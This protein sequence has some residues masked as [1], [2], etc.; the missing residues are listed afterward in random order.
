MNAIKWIHTHPSLMAAAGLLCAT[1]G[2]WLLQMDH[3][4]AGLALYSG[5]AALVVL[6]LRD[7]T[8]PA[9]ESQAGEGVRRVD[10]AQVAGMCVAGAAALL[11]AI[12]LVMQWQRSITPAAAWPWHFVAW[13]AF[14]LGWLI[15]LRRWTWLAL[16]GILSFALLTRTYQL[17]AVPVGLWGDEANDGLEA[18][19]ILRGEVETP[20]RNAWAGNPGLHQ[21]VNALFFQIMGANT[22]TLR[23]VAA[24][25]GL[26]TIGLTYV[27]GRQLWGAPVGLL[28]AFLLTISRWHIHRSRF[29]SVVVQGIPFQLLAYILLMRALKSRR[30]ADFAL[31]GLA[32]GLSLNFYFG[33]RV[34]PI[35]V[36]LVLLHAFASRPSEFI[37]LYWQ[38]CL[39]LIVGVMITFGPVG[40]YY[41]QEPQA[42]MGRT[43]NV[44][45]FAA[46][47]HFRSQYPDMDPTPFNILRT[48]AG[49][50]A[51]M[52]NYQ[53]GA[54]H[55]FNW[56]GQPLLDPL[57]G[58][59]FVLGFCCA[60]WR[61]RERRHA[62]LLAWLLPTLILGSVLTVGAPHSVRTAGA[63]PAVAL[64]AALASDMLWRAL[65]PARRRLRRWAL[66]PCAILWLGLAAYHN[67]DAYF[68]RYMPDPHTWYSRSSISTTLG[69][70]LR[71]HVESYRIA[72]L[73]DRQGSKHNPVL[74]FS[75]GGYEA[76]DFRSPAEMIPLDA[77]GMQGTIFVTFNG[78][79]VSYLDNRYPGGA[80][81]TFSDPW[82]KPVWWTYRVERDVIEDRRGLVGRYYDNL[83]GD[84]QPLFRRVDHE[85]DFQWPLDAPISRPFAVEWTG[86]IISDGEARTLA[87]ETDAPARVWIDGDL[88]IDAPT[89]S[90]GELRLARGH[91]EITI[92]AAFPDGGVPLQLIWAEAGGEF[93]ATP[94][95]V[96][97][98]WPDA[99][100]LLGAYYAN[101]DWAGEPAYYQVDPLMS[102]VW[103]HHDDPLP[104]PFSVE[105][106][107]WLRVEHAGDY[108]FSTRSYDASQIWIGDELVADKARGGAEQV[109]GD[110]IAL[111][112]GEHPIRIRYRGEAGAKAVRVYWTPPDGVEEII[113][114]E[115]LRPARPETR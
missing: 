59:L 85:I 9:V 10:V 17:D 100:G 22:F 6:A 7:A 80:A 78:D 96:L 97:G 108:L 14:V 31:S 90:Q 38:G 32:I 107:G 63:I 89:Q 41:L 93:Q 75:S 2:Q 101:P 54:N 110:P 53:G 72:F 71:P 60:G 21:W 69:Y 87:L 77:T 45:A 66:V 24:L 86:V 25:A 111:T 83:E 18:L 112:T 20:F 94:A 62:F 74:Q 39:A 64:L 102:H 50:T 67:L 79:V 4:A 103:D 8:P 65:W 114:L 37:R 70:Y 49:A 106:Q 19:R 84:G 48:N 46:Q 34:V 82:G 11:A 42:F 51:L 109:Q 23:L 43:Q 13:G 113:P 26:A 29:D 99:P 104:A 115:R 44:W 15:W 58:V 57:T 5:A 76:D 95:A 36:A 68:L 30:V 1:L 12:M 3:L 47:D 61:W 73:W 33:M 16:I 56:A 27:L 105:W 52:F 92:R 91:H 40:M 28:A 35:I 88:V 98:A 81:T 55:V